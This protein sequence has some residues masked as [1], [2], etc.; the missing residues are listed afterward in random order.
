MI[1]HRAGRSATL[2]VFLMFLAALNS[3]AQE[4]SK[5]G[6][7][8]KAVESMFSRAGEDA[9][10]V[11]Q[12]IIGTTVKILRSENDAQGG[13]WYWIE[14]PDTYQGWMRASAIRVM[15]PAQKPYASE[16]RVFEV[17]SLI[18]YVYEIKDV[19]EKSPLLLAPISAVLEVGECGERWCAITLPG[20]VKG[21]VQKGDGELHDAGFQKPR[22]SPQ[23]MANLARRFLGLPYFWG[24]VTPLGLDCSGFVQLIYRL[25]GIEI[26]RDADIQM[27][28]S[29]LS[30]VAP[31]Q[32]KAGD[33]V[34]FGR[35]KEAIVHVGMMV[36]QE[37]FISATTWIRPEV[38]ISKLSELHWKDL[39]QGARR[40]KA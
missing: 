6:V 23:E 19:T 33:L 14:T 10:V 29:G 7:V 28:K 1:I 30:D 16:G 18:A 27:T 40:P 25:G 31:G 22:L 34:F 36:N 21:W 20:G 9:A 26:L 32:E 35:S 8:I 37:E 39:Y 11:S 24:G 38:Q 13:E 5:R 2:I 4:T 3:P 15:G 12:A 17:S